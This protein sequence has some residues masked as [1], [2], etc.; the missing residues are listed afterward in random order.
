MRLRITFDLSV[1]ESVHRTTLVGHMV[2]A[3]EDLGC[4]VKPHVTWEP[5]PDLTLIKGTGGDEPA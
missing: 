2:E 5:L 4:S 3:A 1:P